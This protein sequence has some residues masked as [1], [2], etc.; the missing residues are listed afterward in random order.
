MR[1]DAGGW[2]WTAV[3]EVLLL[4]GSFFF[5]FPYIPSNEMAHLPYQPG[6]GLAWVLF[7]ASRALRWRRKWPMLLL[8]LPLF[9]LFTSSLHSA[10]D[11]LYRV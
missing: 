10:I 2:G 6:A 3:A 11:L 7:A 4:F 9:V 8:E 1:L 5:L